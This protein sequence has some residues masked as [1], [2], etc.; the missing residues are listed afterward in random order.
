MSTRTANAKWNGTLKEGMGKM[1]F[2]NYSGPY[3][4]KSRFEEGDGTNPEELVGAAIAGCYSMFLASLIS[5]E[6]LQPESVETVARVHLE[7]DDIGPLIT[8]IELD[9]Q[10]KC[11]GLSYDKLKEL[12]A[13]AKEKCP[14][15]RLYAATEK[16][17]EAKLL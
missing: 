7:R 4:F 2:S 10:V 6:N 8:T 16:K 3:T 12:A 9:T 14:V 1:N 17:L 13:A 15:S 5:S 11:E